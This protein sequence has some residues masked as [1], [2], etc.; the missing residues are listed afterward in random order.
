M[1]QSFQSLAVGNHGFVLGL[2]VVGLAE[3]V[4]DIPVGDN[5]LADRQTGVA[6]PFTSALDLFLPDRGGHCPSPS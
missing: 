3:Y 6:H 4:H 1:N 2:G 5:D